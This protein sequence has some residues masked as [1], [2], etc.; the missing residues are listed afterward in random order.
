MLCRR[1]NILLRQG[2]MSSRVKMW[3]TTNDAILSRPHKNGSGTTWFT[4]GLCEVASNISCRSDVVRNQEDLQFI[5][6]DHNGFAPC[7]FRSVLIVSALD[8]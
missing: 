4:K 2:W 1:L 5:P 6:A 7:N 8:T 3:Q